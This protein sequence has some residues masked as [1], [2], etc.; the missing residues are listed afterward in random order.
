MLQ[1]PRHFYAS[2]AEL[3]RACREIGLVW[4][5]IGKAAGRDDVVA[6]GAALLAV[7][8]LL[9]HDMHASLN[10]TVATTSNPAAPR[11]WPFLAD[12]T[13]ST[14]E[15]ECGGWGMNWACAGE[16]PP[17]AIA[18]PPAHAY[19]A[20]PEMMWSGALTA[21]QVDDTYK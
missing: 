8:P 15:L 2:A 17:P 7:A 12:V 14:I 10:R 3:Y 18:Q 16:T 4:A 13:H 21:Q 19:K 9:H 6:H 1:P 5:E 20:Y 11:H